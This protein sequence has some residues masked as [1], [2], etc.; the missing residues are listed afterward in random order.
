M[1]TRSRQRAAAF[2]QSAFTLTEAV[3]SIALIAICMTTIIMTMTRLNEEA[4]ITRNATGASA[5]VQNQIDLLLSDGPFNPQKNNSDGMPQIPPELTVGTHV[6]NNIPIYREPSTGIVVAGT[7]TTSVV[8]IS[9][10]VDSIAQPLYRADVT[11]T[12]TYRSRDYTVKRSTLRTS[13][14]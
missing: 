14:I 7:L 6:T 8:D 10:V 13:D 4:S 3:V 12:Y 2:R 1:I 9:P 11:V 5:V